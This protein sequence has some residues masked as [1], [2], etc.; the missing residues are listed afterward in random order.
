MVLRLCGNGGVVQRSSGEI[1][2]GSCRFP[3]EVVSRKGA[4][5]L[6]NYHIPSKEAA[7]LYR[8]LLRTVQ[9]HIRPRSKA[10][11]DI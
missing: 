7:G 10:Y 8:A 1:I 3:R 9:G 4:A 2:Q 5:I 6:I 11:A